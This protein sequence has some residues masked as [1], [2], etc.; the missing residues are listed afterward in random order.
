MVKCVVCSCE[1]A[2]EKVKHIEVKG[3]VK[4]ICPGCVTAIK[5]II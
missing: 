1:M 4:K 5:G 3:T 2:E